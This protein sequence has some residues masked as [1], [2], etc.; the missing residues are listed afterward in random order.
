MMKRFWKAGLAGLVMLALAGAA[1]GIVAAQTG[2]GTATPDPSATPSTTKR[3]QLVDDFLTKLAGNLGISVDTLKQAIGTTDNQMLDQAVKDG[4]I[5]DAEAATIRDRIANGDLF[6]FMR[7][8]HGDRGFGLRGD[9]L[10]ETAS[11]LGITEQDVKDGLQNNQNLA[12]IAKAHGKTADELS[13]H[14]YD[15]LKARL[16]QAVTNGKI[17][18]AREDNMLSN[19][20]DR[21]DQL[22]THAGPPS[23]KGRFDVQDM[24]PQGS[25]TGSPT[26]TGSSL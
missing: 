17:T 23:F 4:K 16:D 12:D 22:I 26:E 2:G 5:T 13:S 15:A 19:A 8:R 9:L 21:I 14:L 20:K 7:G 1:A 6:P 18:Q 11:F 3:A 25:P 10:S 24:T